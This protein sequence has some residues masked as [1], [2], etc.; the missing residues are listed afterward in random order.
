MITRA[1]F[2]NL[3]IEG[4][5]LLNSVALL[6]IIQDASFVMSETDALDI[7]ASRGTPVQVLKKDFLRRDLPRRRHTKMYVCM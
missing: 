5:L 2:V 7:Y 1:A 4:A 6:T 3:S